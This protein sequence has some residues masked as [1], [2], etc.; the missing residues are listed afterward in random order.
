MQNF[1]PLVSIIVLNYNGSQFLADCFN[2]LRSVSYPNYEVIMVDNASSDESVGFVAQ[3]FPEVKILRNE[4]NLGFTAGNNRGAGIA[5]GKYLFFLNND[6]KVRPDFLDYLV[7]AAEEDDT[8][9]ICACKILTFEGKEEAQINYTCEGKS[10]GCTG[11]SSDIY[12]WQGWEGPVF[13]AEGSALFARKE[14]FDKL[15]GFDEQHFIFLEDLDLAWRT[16]LLGFKIKAVPESMIYHFA[17]GTVTGGRGRK[18]VFISNIRR[19]YLGEKNQM[20]NVLKNYSL[21]T[22]LNVLPRYL[23]LN[24]GEMLYFLIKGEFKVLW[25]AYIRAH[26]WNIRHLKNTLRE[27]KKVQSM[28]KVPDC[29]LQKNML[30]HSAKLDTFMRIGAPQFK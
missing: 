2:S 21:A 18:Q 22:L 29:A 24:T 14:I 3:N 4:N 11:R 15:G 8:A 16:Q 20:R 5:R 12:G 30:K 1:K 7:A 9:G 13:F 28:R 17:G 26:I 25:Q 23:I 6:T 19:R 27:R 10:V